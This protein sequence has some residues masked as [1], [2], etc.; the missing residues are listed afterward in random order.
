M[1][2]LTDAP[3]I[4]LP[5][6]LYSF[7]TARGDERESIDVIENVFTRSIPRFPCFLANAQPPSARTATPNAAMRMTPATVAVLDVPAPSEDFVSAG[8]V[9]GR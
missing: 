1:L 9:P 8:R 4:S 2:E 3:H 7:I 6:C 5:S